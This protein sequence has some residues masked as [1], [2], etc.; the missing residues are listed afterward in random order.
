VRWAVLAAATWAVLPASY[1]TIG[2]VL[3]REDFSLCWFALHLW[4]LARALR[5]RTAGSALLATAA[6][7]LFVATWHAASFVFALEALLVLCWYLR[8]G[9]NPLASRRAAAC[10]ALLVAGTLL[11]PALRARFFALLAR[12]LP[13]VKVGLCWVPWTHRRRYARGRT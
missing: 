4:L 2:F 12:G 5:L 7:V 3:V 11:S 9:E 8:T 13:K 1:R 6:L 10:V